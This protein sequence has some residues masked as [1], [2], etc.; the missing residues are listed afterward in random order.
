MKVLAKLVAVTVFTF[1]SISLPSIVATF[2]A[3]FR[4]GKD[5]V[6]SKSKKIAVKMTA[7]IMYNSCSEKIPRGFSALFNGSAKTLA[8][9]WT[10]AKLPTLLQISECLQAN[11]AALLALKPLSN[12]LS[13]NVHLVNTGNLARFL[14]QQSQR[15]V[16]VEVF[17]MIVPFITIE[18][19]RHDLLLLLVEGCV[20]RQTEIQ[21]TFAHHMPAA[22]CPHHI[23]VLGA[24]KHIL[25]R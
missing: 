1:A 17:H 7:T 14:V 23:E 24:I 22:F 5:L 8:E 12:L 20:S 25:G 6:G 21:A 18:R 4:R 9:K 19:L 10:C 13:C 15:D 3:T 16:L 2:W 11:A